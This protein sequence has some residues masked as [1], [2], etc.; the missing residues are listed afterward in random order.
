MTSYGKGL[1]K[2][3]KNDFGPVGLSFLEYYACMQAFVLSLEVSV[4]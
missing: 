2:I 1:I 3:R 4:E